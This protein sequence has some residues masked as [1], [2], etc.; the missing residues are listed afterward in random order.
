MGMLGLAT[1][2]PAA[3]CR[4]SFF[5]WSVSASAVHLRIS[6]HISILM[7]PSHGLERTAK[8]RIT[9]FHIHDPVARRYL[10]TGF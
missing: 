7:Q 9:G 3:S 2:L 4:W 10:C 1:I 6:L 8:V 5:S